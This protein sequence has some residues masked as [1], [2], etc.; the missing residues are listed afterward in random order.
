MSTVYKATNAKNRM[1]MLSNAPTPSDSAVLAKLTD[2]VFI[3]VS[4]DTVGKYSLSAIPPTK[5]KF[6]GS[7]T[8]GDCFYHVFSSKYTDMDKPY[9]PIFLMVEMTPSTT[10]TQGT[11][12][13]RLYHIASTHILGIED[14][15]IAEDV[16]LPPPLAFL[17]IPSRKKTLNPVNPQPA[18]VVPAATLQISQNNSKFSTAN[19]YTVK[20][21]PRKIIESSVQT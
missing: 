19:T 7:M 2:Y 8:F 1:Q 9:N 13:M 17:D 16:T 15:V 5:K 12:D 21:D 20:Y 18:Q 6:I 10:S 14:W 4:I 3:R 11:F